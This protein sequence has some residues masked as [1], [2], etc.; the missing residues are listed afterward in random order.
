MLLLLSITKIIIMKKSVLFLLMFLFSFSL[1]AQFIPQDGLVLHLPFA[2]NVNNLGSLTTNPFT[3]SELGYTSSVFGD[4]INYSASIFNGT[5]SEVYTSVPTAS[6]QGISNAYTVSAWVNIY[7]WQG[8]YTNIFEIEVSNFLRMSQAGGLFR[9]EHGY[10][11]GNGNYQILVCDGGEEGLDTAD[12]KNVW[13]HILITSEINNVGIR[14][15]SAYLNGELLCTSAV[16]NGQNTIVYNGTDQRFNIGHRMISGTYSM[17][18]YGQMAH[19]TW[20][21]RVLSQSEITDMSCHIDRTLTLLDGTYSASPNAEFYQ[22]INCA[23]DAPVIGQHTAT[24]TPPSYGTYRVRLF[25]DYCITESECV[26]YA[27]PVSVSDFSNNL[28]VIVFPNPS[29]DVVYIENA[30]LGSVMK[31]ISISGQIVLEN[32]ID[33][34]KTSID[35]SSL[36]SGLY[37]IQIEN[38]NVIETMKLIVE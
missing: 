33:S 36:K 17:P 28:A 22:W 7:D 24:F 10:L 11:D 26:E 27:A 19:F 8:L 3:V 2:G 23:T 5:D 35:V 38:T 13:S 34:D 37:I 12:Y 31:L 25:T 30:L 18:F 29:K 21:N 9:I 16:N 20:H 15:M 1:K 32:I 6:A 14:Q 4:E